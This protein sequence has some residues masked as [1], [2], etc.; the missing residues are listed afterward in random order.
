MTDPTNPGDISVVG[1]RRRPGGS[2][3]GGGGGGKDE[4]IGEVPE[5]EELPD[6]LEEVTPDPCADSVLAV[7]WNAD[8]AAAEAFSGFKVKAAELGDTGLY[9]REFGA[10][11]YQHPDGSIYLGPIT[12]GDPMTGTFNFDESGMTQANLVGEIHSH[13]S[14]QMEPS[15]ADWTRLNTFSDWTQRN[16]RTYIA[17]RDQN[18]PTS[19]FA[20]RVYDKSSDQSSD[21]PGPEVNPEAKPCP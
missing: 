9:Q 7:D 6:P 16:F 12:W 8:A 11:I 3:P 17:S 21:N 2:F 1:Q 10:K 18:D 13:P 14:P 20:V 5:T 4:T 19:D 15:A